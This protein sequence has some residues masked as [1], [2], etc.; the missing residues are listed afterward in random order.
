[1]ARP[2]LYFACDTQFMNDV[3]DQFA[4]PVDVSLN[5]LVILVPKGN[6]QGVKSLKDLGKPGLKI[7]IGHEK[8]CA[9][10]VLTQE[11]LRQSRV[12]EAVMK[13]VAVQTPTGD[14]LVNQMR[15]GSLDAV[16]AYIS[17][18]VYAADL[19]EP[20][21]VDIPCALAVQPVAVGRESKRSNLA[22][23]LIEAIKSPESRKQFENEGFRWK[24]TAAR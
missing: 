8:Q 17:N 3:K 21:A 6:P 14:M 23:R 16:V 12:Q 24:G 5:Q 10:G 11:T 4:T 2:D 1:G 22:D 7:G 13:N 9:L 15:T 18:A 19:L 20:I